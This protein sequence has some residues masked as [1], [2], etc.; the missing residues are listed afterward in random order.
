MDHSPQEIAKKIINKI[1]YITIASVTKDG[2]PWN[3]PVYSA[4]D[5]EYNFYW[6]S[7]KE[8]QHS[9][10]IKENNNIFIAIYDSTVPWGEGRGVFIQAKAYEIT[11]EDEIVNGLAVLDKRAGKTIG[12]ASEYMN[13]NPRR[14]YKAVPEKIWI[15]DGSKVNG[16]Y[17]DIR[18]EV[19]LR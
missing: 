15:N 3:S 10:N 9:K 13:D 6:R 4:F 16:K 14:V 11:N 5:S 8:S 2:L 12:D 7:N 19:N 18:I 17:V 1:I